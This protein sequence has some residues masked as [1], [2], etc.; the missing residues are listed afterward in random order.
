[1]PSLENMSSHIS[2]AKQDGPG[3]ESTSDW[4]AGSHF[5]VMKNESK[6]L[7]LSFLTV[8]F[9]PTRWTIKGCHMSQAQGGFR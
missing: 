6:M 4:T 5:V 9:T 7:S 1:M 2:T 3:A 8:I